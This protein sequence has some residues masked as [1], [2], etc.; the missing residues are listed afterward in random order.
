MNIQL[1]EKEV[2]AIIRIVGA[3][4]VGKIIDDDAFTGLLKIRQTF[5]KEEKKSSMFDDTTSIYS[6]PNSEFADY[7]LMLADDMETSG[8]QATADDYRECARRLK[9]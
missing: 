8:M 9:R 3:M 7:L 1:S 5:I 6:T 2:S 4:K